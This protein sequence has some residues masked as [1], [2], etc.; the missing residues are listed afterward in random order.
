MHAGTQDV[1]FIEPGAFVVLRTHLADFP[2]VPVFHCHLLFHEDAGMMST[3]QINA[4]A[5]AHLCEGNYLHAKA[6][7]ER[8]HP[9]DIPR[10]RTCR[11]R[12]RRAD[13]VCRSRIPRRWW[14]QET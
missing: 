4:H 7:C 1:I 6:D 8:N 9:M 13:R 11:Q 12:A 3:L 14:D 2:G 5:T 10:Y